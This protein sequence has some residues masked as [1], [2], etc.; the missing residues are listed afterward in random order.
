MAAASGR[1]DRLGDAI[2]QSL[3]R[4]VGWSGW[5]DPLKALWLL[6]G[7]ALLRLPPLR[8]YQP[9]LQADAGFRLDGGPV[10]CTLNAIVFYRGVYE[11]VLGELMRHLIRDGDLCVDVGAN[12][13]YFSLLA[14][15]RVGATGR[16]VA[17]EASPANVARIRRNV[18]L[19]GLDD[20]VEVVAAACSDRQG[21]LV[22]YVNEANDMH[23]RLDLPQRGEADYWLVRGRWR[24]VTVA[25]TTLA[26]V[27]GERAA[28]VTFI[29]LDIEGAEPQVVPDILA[30]CTHPQLHVAL[31][32]KATHL[33]ET[34]EPFERAGFHL[35]DLRNDYRWL[36]NART[37][38]PR[39]VRFDEVYARGRM[40]DVLL[41]RQPLAPGL[42]A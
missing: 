34:L 19:N 2:R 4:C 20:R 1:I 40:A 36:V 8:A 26:A 22:F 25:A 13:G 14:A 41:A 24:P 16:V 39:A 27:L 18:A 17:V 32:A 37:R 12:A 42:L 7:F 9:P 28:Q 31:E 38:R 29:K 23:C 30:H 21:E 10:D 33:R 6:G 11:P 35:Y 3:R 5:L 15:A